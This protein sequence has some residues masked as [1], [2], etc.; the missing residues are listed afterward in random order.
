MN[1]RLAILVAVGASI[2]GLTIALCVAHFVRSECSKPPLCVEDAQVRAVVDETEFAG[3]R[4]HS[5]GAFFW[6]SVQSE[7]QDAG[8]WVRI[9]RTGR[10][11]YLLMVVSGVNGRH[12]GAPRAYGQGAGFE[13]YRAFADKPSPD[14]V[15]KFI[16]GVP[17]GRLSA[18]YDTCTQLEKLE[19]CT[20]AHPQPRQQQKK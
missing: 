7:L 16:N 5:Y 3:A 4:V 13:W 15:T 1:R 6:P 8:L 14:D 10:D 12:W 20:K 9:S 18:A 19:A 11:K 2:A 17:A